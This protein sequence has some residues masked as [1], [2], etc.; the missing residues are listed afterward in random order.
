MDLNGSQNIG[1][2]HS[3]GTI[4]TSNFL[5]STDIFVDGKLVVQTDHIDRYFLGL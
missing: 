3:S 4:T 5:G 1:I 2:D